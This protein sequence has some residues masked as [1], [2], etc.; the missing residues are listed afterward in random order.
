MQRLPISAPQNL[1]F[2]AEN[3]DDV[4]LT[5]EQT[6]NST[7]SSDIIDN[8]FGSGVLP[9]VLVPNILFNSATANGLMDGYAVGVQAQPSDPNLGNQLSITLSG[10][11]AA[12]RRTVKVLIIG[13]N[14]EN[15]LQYDRFT[16]DRNGT[17][18]SS[19]HYT[20]ILAIL[21][22]D[23]VG[24]SSQSL[25]L[26]GTVIIQ[27]AAQLQLSPD[28]IMISQD[29][30][31]NL[32]FRDFFVPLTTSLDAV[33]TNALTGYNVDNLNI[34]SGYLTLQTFNIG[35][36]SSQIGQ[37]FLASS[38][39]IQKITLLLSVQNLITPTDLQW[40]GNLIISLYSLQT[41]VS[42]IT[43]IV[44]QLA[45]QFDPS[46][47]PLAQLSLSYASLQSSGI[48]L[49][50]VPQPVDFV[51]SNTPVG[52]NAAIIPGNYYAITA[53]MAGSTNNCQLQFAV[54]SNSSSNTWETLFNGNVWA[55]VPTQSLWFQVW[56]DAAK[57]A[58]GQAYDRGHGAL[59][60][61]TE[62]NPDTGATQDYSLGQLP[63][64]GDTLYSALFQADITQSTPVQNE[65]T[66][67]TSN[68]EQQYT[69]NISL[70]NELQLA[71]IQNVA[72]PL[73]IGT[74][75]DF[76]VDAFSSTN[77]ILTSFMHEYGLVKNQLVLKVITDPTDGYRYDTSIIELV[78]EVVNNNLYGGQFITDTT[79]PALFYRISNAEILTMI[80]GDVNG[81][82]VVDNNDV[83]AAQNLFGQNLNYMPSEQQYIANTTYFVEDI[84]LT[85]QVVDPHLGVVASGT[86]GILMPNP[87]NGAL[88]N[89]QS[90]SAN[91]ASITNLGNDTIVISNSSASQGN[92][93]SFLITNLV[94]N[95]N[96]TIMKVYYT[97]DTILEILRADVSGDMVVGVDDI[98]Y[99]SNYANC[100]PPFPATTPPAN[101][102][103]T[104]FTCIRLTFEQYVDRFDDYDTDPNDRDGYVHPLPDLYL[105]GYGLFAGD[106]LEYNP[107]QFSIT[108][109]LVWDAQAILANS[110]PRL[111]E[112]SFNYQTGGIIDPEPPGVID[113]SF[114]IPPPFDPGRND[115]LI[116]NNLI[117]NGGQIITP[118]GYFF[119]VDLEVVP[120]VLE[121]PSPFNDGYSDGYSIN[122]LTDVVANYSGTGYTRIGNPAMKFSDGSFVSMQAIVNNQVMF[123]VALQSYSPQLTGIDPTCLEGII[124]D[125]KIGVSMDFATGVLTLNFNNL[126]QDPVLQ[127]LNTKLQVMVHLKKA[128]W[129]NLPVYL[130]SARLQNI[131]GI[132]TPT[133][134]N[135]S[136]PPPSMVIIP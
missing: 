106:D 101:K 131:L 67:N 120:V 11:A 130:S 63:F 90:A 118:D 91:F 44:P 100:T 92:D 59:V 68:S 26:G 115:I 1:F 129:N 94:D 77:T 55:D 58:D 46:N 80:Y 113:Q 60:P 16:F 10:S 66:G 78:S 8:H 9:D 74:I 33:L 43:D 116:P 85:W 75:E 87:L 49:N 103:G 109:Q 20:I 15:T 45:I 6:Y 98:Q 5:L 35:D 88:A 32:F 102:I 73:I 29:V 22:N 121:M 57:V 47:I 13:L 133:P 42:C 50:T 41:S 134:A 136:C 19:K 72:E 107:V 54:G 135:I 62:I 64:V 97:S 21:F 127:T 89:F 70:L 95:H 82:G 93:G 61:K 24:V 7:I 52:N 83:L 123:Q 110:N 48:V 39:N 76:N 124:V 132:A 96:L 27:E 81:D 119:K 30:Q 40:T 79:N 2:D 69:P 34:T 12:G 65:R 128:G 23:L 112:C 3:I 114:P 105:D 38:N 31:P 53:K 37:K 71:N 104:T 36:V 4:A 84:H 111:V 25:N 17:Q 18:V 117:M 56:T 108:K 51:F 28:P 99:I 14:F 122:L 126:Y 86:D 125:G